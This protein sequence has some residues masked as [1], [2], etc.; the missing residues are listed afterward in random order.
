MA[1]LG[2]GIQQKGFAHT[3]LIFGRNAVD[4]SVENSSNGKMVWF[5]SWTLFRAEILGPLCLSMIILLVHPGRWEMRVF[6]SSRRTIGSKLAQSS[7]KEA[8]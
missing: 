6:L 5:F 1:E 3:S 7:N 4:I 8:F 2:D